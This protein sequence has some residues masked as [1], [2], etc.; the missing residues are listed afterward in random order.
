MM[1]VFIGPNEGD[2]KYA[3]T[4]IQFEFGFSFT[5]DDDLIQGLIL[6]SED[7]YG[8]NPP[9]AILKAPRMEMCSLKC[10]LLIESVF[11]K[12]D[13]IVTLSPRKDPMADEIREIIFV[14]IMAPDPRVK[15]FNDMIVPF[16]PILETSL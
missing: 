9:L 4:S 6:G 1:L 7:F 2:S 10:F 3:L 14:E 11:E 5:F 16:G 13:G 12:I 8:E 15:I